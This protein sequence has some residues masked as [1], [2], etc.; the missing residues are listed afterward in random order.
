MISH[1]AVGSYALLDYIEIAPVGCLGTVVP[2]ERTVRVVV[3]KCTTSRSQT[4]SLYVTYRPA[5]S[6]G[7][8]MRTTCPRRIPK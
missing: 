3:L 8:M 1:Y 7:R 6:E 5:V 2:T 4:Q